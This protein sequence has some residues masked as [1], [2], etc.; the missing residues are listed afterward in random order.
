MYWSGNFWFRWRFSCVVWFFFFSENCLM[1][2]FGWSRHERMSYWSRH[3]VSFWKLPVE[4]ACDVYLEQMLERTCEFWKESKY[5]PPN[6]RWCSCIG[7]SCKSLLGFLRLCWCWCSVMTFLHWFTLQWFA[8]LHWWHL[9]WFILHSL[10]ILLC[11]DFEERNTPKN[12]WWYSSCFLP[13]CKEFP[14]CQLVEPCSFFWI[15]RLLLI[16]F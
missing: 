7:L 11:C 8:G 9:H 12:F 5:N 3:V 15:E 1:R 10:L 13:R 16:C 6:S 4:R 2:L 14:S